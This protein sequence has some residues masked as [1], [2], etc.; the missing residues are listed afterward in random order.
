MADNGREADDH[1]V[2]GAAVKPRD[3]GRNYK[4]IMPKYVKNQI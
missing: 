4:W 1:P 2:E 3:A